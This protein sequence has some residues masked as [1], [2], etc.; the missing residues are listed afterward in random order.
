MAAFTIA[1]VTVDIVAGHHNL[2]AVPPS[3]WHG[4]RSEQT[5][6]AVLANLYADDGL[7][8][9]IALVQWPDGDEVSLGHAELFGGPADYERL[10]DVGPISPKRLGKDLVA[11]IRALQYGDAGWA[12]GA[13]TDWHQIDEWSAT[14][15]HG[16]L[17][18]LGA[19]GTGTYAEVL[20]GATRFKSEPA[21][22]VPV[23]DPRAL[24]AVYAMTRVMP[25][26]LGHGKSAVE[27]P[28]R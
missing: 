18:D 26:M 8:M 11:R 10:E 19:G 12:G 3:Q 9:Q 25:I 22:A 23:S 21:V 5:G 7:R 27:G 16:A 20:P 24:F 2:T 17:A 28:H 4:D 13:V 1:N 15:A 14:D 6:E